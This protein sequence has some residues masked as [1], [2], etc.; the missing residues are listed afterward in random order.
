MKKQNEFIGFTIIF[1]SATIIMLPH[2]VQAADT[3]SANDSIKINFRNKKMVKE[4]KSKPD[5][6]QKN[7]KKIEQQLAIMQGEKIEDDNTDT[8]LGGFFSSLAGTVFFAE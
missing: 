5:D 7:F 2:S 1:L 8:Y 6:T 4:K 3:Y